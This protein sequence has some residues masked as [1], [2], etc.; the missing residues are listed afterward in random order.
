MGD[1]YLIL[2][3]LLLPPGI[4]IL[5]LAIGVLMLFR[6]RRG[7]QVVL[8]IT[9]LAFY[10][11]STPAVATRLAGALIVNAP[12]PSPVPAGTCD[13][14][15]VL[16]GGLYH[17]SPE[18]GRESFLSDSTLWRVTY[19][20]QVARESQTPLLV[21]GGR[22]MRT[23]TSEAEAMR[24]HLE[25]QLAQ[26][27]RWVEDQA[28]NTWEQAKAV[29]TLLGPEKITRICLVTH[30]THMP[31]AEAAFRAEGFDVVPAATD[32]RWA[33]LDVRLPWLPQPGAF[34]MSMAALHEQLGRAA[35]AARR[36]LS[37]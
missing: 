9:L 6:F 19:G 12:L 4:L 36:W 5:L 22:P 15:V 10:A 27:V 17:P 7:G 25:Q 20:A 37:V 13:A 14:V 24:D 11:L 35:Y 29:A 8:A 30:A 16:G 26:P 3:N 1:F 34:G 18:F 23:E 33:N 2:K 28:R 21:S 32:F 31:R